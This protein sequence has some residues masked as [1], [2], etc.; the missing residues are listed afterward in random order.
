MSNLNVSRNRDIQI[1]VEGGSFDAY[2]AAPA[3]P[4]PA[5]IVIGSVFGVTASLRADCD[6]LA[7]SGFLAIAPDLFW[8][9][10]PGPLSR[11]P[12]ERTRAFA[13]YGA[14]DIDLGVAD[15]AATMT[16]AR[17]QPEH[18]GGVAVLGYCFGGSSHILQRHGS[19]PMPASPFTARK[20]ESFCLKAQQSPRR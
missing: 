11:E 14:F 12:E 16:F 10:D 4:G 13:R 9:T 15:V 8:R 18:R 17:E 7:A 20:S 1:N 19:A 2:F 6:A 5:V 3:M